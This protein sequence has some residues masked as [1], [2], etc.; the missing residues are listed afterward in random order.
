M[1]LSSYSDV[2]SI[3]HD[4]EHDEQINAGDLVRSGPNLYPHFEVVA[5]HG[6]KA[7]VR[8]V[9]NGADHLAPLSRCRKLQP[10][11]LAIAAE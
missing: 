2:F 4:R 5:V 10:E 8:N 11:P 9:L 3:N 1:S 6:D 7:W